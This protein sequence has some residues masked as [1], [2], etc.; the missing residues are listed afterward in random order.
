MDPLNA[1]NNERAERYRERA[2]EC[3]RLSQTLP[4]FFARKTFAT[5]ADQWLALAIDAET[6]AFREEG[7]LPD[8]Q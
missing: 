8:K 6:T 1:M 2:L 7:H 5:M 4:D 3:A